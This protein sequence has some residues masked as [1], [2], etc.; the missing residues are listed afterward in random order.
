M[1]Y[2]TRRRRHD[3]TLADK[4]EIIRLIDN[5]TSQTDVAKIYNCSQS[6]ISRI[7]SRR[8]DIDAEWEACD[9]PEQKKRRITTETDES[10][11]VAMKDEDLSQSMDQSRSPYP[12]SESTFD[13]SS[14]QAQ[15]QTNDNGWL[16]Y[17]KN[18][19]STF[20]RRSYR[21][22]DPDFSPW[23]RHL[24][25]GSAG[26]K[27]QGP[28]GRGRPKAL[29]KKES[30]I[31][32]QLLDILKNYD[33][34]D[35]YCADELALHYDAMPNMD[36]AE[37]EDGEEG[38]GEGDSDKKEKMSETN[39]KQITVLLTCNVTGADKRDFLIIE[40]SKKAESETA[41]SIPGCHRA[42]A[43]HAWM[44]SDVYREFLTAL[45]YS[46]R[47]QRRYI[48][49]LVD[50]APPHIPEA[51][52]SLEHVRVLYIRSY[53]TPFFHG[54][55]Y[56]MRSHYRK[57]I[58]LKLF[59]KN[60]ELFANGKPDGNAA[61]EKGAPEWAVNVDFEDA[62]SMLKQAWTSVCPQDIVQC[63]SKSGICA[64]HIHGLPETSDDSLPEL[65]EGFISDEQF[66]E[67]I[68]IDVDAE[69]SADSDLLSA[70]CRILSDLR[71]QG[72]TD[73]GLEPSDDVSMDN[74][75]L[76]FAALSNTSVENTPSV[77]GPKGDLP[78]D[79]SEVHGAL[80]AVRNFLTRH[81]LHLNNLHALEEQIFSCDSGGPK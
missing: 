22:M 4:K 26:K 40:D 74:S 48:L 71:Q 25:P 13:G 43:P 64:P 3:L 67:Y 69:C 19:S 59:A 9:D 61:K 78:E 16:E 53:T 47:K 42:K 60:P 20:G 24:G 81:D 37:P 38:E 68:N 66:E 73:V 7:V 79:S 46:M 14:G 70:E 29:F 28:G 41:P 58:L 44:T 52:K 62:V 21:D 56:S 39:N 80:V 23:S 77:A 45:D 6:Q 8:E 2:A 12:P 72:F 49:L 65:P 51:G 31:S 63:F 36:G 33:L 1:S 55:F 75:G 17:W 18:H 11:Q 15:T 32:N 50:N 76:N 10:S 35:V 57:Q 30:R 54:I 27:L 34:S 5:R